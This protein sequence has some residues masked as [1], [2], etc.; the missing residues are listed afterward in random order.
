MR[1]IILLLLFLY[2]LL[3]LGVETLVRKYDF[4][5]Y[6]KDISIKNGTILLKGFSFG[7]NK[8][9]SKNFSFYANELTLGKELTARGIFINF[10]NL[11]QPKKKDLSS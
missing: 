7:F 9:F 4:Y 6:I 1:I 2:T 3:P 10:I 11:K 5:L 8:L